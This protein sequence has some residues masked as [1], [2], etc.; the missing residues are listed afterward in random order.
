MFSQCQT[1]EKPVNIFANF[2]T[3]KRAKTLAL[4]LSS[5]F[6]AR[7]LSKKKKMVMHEVVYKDKPKKPISTK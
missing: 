5:A 4:F 6:F 2:H 7:L 1:M 3:S